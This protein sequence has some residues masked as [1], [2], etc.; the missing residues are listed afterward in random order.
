MLA[1]SPLI[2]AQWLAARTN[3]IGKGVRRRSG[4]R[5]KVK[6]CL[7]FPL[8]NLQAGKGWMTDEDEKVFDRKG[9]FLKYY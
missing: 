1:T 9:D 2:V 5:S 7:L 8:N 3:N 6:G 4:V